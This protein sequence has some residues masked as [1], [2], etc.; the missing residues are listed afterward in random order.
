MKLDPGP[1]MVE[2]LLIAIMMLSPA[3]FL[4]AQGVENKTTQLPPGS[5]RYAILGDS[6]IYTAM[7]RSWLAKDEI[8][9]LSIPVVSPLGDYRVPLRSGEGSSGSL[10]LLEAKLD[11]RFPIAMGRPSSTGFYRRGRL[12]FD[13]GANFRMTLDNSKPL[14]PWSNRVGIGFD[15]T[16]WD[17]YTKIKPWK[18]RSLYGDQK[19]LDMDKNLQFVT[20]TIKAHHYSNGQ[21]P[22]FFFDTIVD[23][24]PERRN[25]YLSGDFSTN[26]LFTELSWGHLNTKTHALWQLSAAYRRDGTGFP[27]ALIFSEEQNNSYGQNRVE[28]AFDWRSG[29]RTYGQRVEYLEADGKKY[30]SD[31]LREWHFRYQ[32][33]VILG[34]LSAFQAN[35][36]DD[37]GKYR[38]AHR[39]YF[40]YTHLKWRSL[41]LMGMVYYGRDYLNIRYDI[42]VASVQFGATLQLD[43]FY[44]IGWNSA[45]STH[46]NP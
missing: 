29:P 23:G 25:D 36:K 8:S 4:Q 5:S 3:C 40:T 30:Y 12:T 9:Y 34:N 31:K 42:P 33:S 27:G 37:D 39:V 22:G 18:D 1:C 32:G 46:R 41:S 26:Y 20:L 38:F 10:Q 28:Y 35:L 14:T 15:Y 19:R 11:F 7:N 43:K 44:P 6:T 24:Q 21:P 13:Y 45:K 2:R 17:N 16:L